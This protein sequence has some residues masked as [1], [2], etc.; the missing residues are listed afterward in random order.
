[1]GVLFEEDARRQLLQ[2][3]GFADALAAAQQ[4]QRGASVARASSTGVATAAEHLAAAAEQ[5]TLGDGALP[6]ARPLSCSC[7]RSCRQQACLH[8]SAPPTQPTSPRALPAGCARPRPQALRPRAWTCRRRTMTTSST[9]P[10]TRRGFS[11]TSPTRRRPSRRRP[12]PAPATSRARARTAAR[13]RSR[14]R[15][16]ARQAAARRRRGRRTSRRRCLW[17]TTTAPWRCASRCGGGGLRGGV[18]GVDALVCCGCGARRRTVAAIGRQAEGPPAWSL[19]RPRRPHAP[20][21]PPRVFQA[22]RLAD[23]L[24]IANIGGAELFKRTMHRYM[25]R[26][27]RPYMTV[28]ALLSGRGSGGAGRPPRALQLPCAPGATA[29]SGLHRSPERPAHAPAPTRPPPPP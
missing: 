28:R 29:P 25:R 2:K 27:P 8:A 7:C 11:T 21:N 26:S 3:L 19:S 6:P 4:Q 18:S 10:T 24:L 17:A 12:R 13:R 20:L 15:R 22:N 1:M 9:R 5:M 16:S 14:R 23:A